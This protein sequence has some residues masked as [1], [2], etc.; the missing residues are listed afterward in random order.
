MICRAVKHA[1]RTFGAFTE[2]TLECNDAARKAID[3]LCDD[4]GFTQAWY[5]ERTADGFSKMKKIPVLIL[6]K[7][8]LGLPASREDAV[9]SLKGAY[10]ISMDPDLRTCMNVIVGRRPN[11]SGG[12]VLDKF[13]LYYPDNKAATAKFGTEWP[14]IHGYS[15]RTAALSGT[16]NRAGLD[17]LRQ[18]T[19]QAVN[20]GL[21][22]RA[23]DH[24]LVID[25][26]SAYEDCA[27]VS[28][29]PDETDEMRKQRIEKMVKAMAAAYGGDRGVLAMSF[30]PVEQAQ[31][32]TALQSEWTLLQK[33]MGSQ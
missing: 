11:G 12:Y 18:G 24:G 30:D 3:S 32:V 8:M 13:S 17:D 15:F 2:K 25:E 29:P 7:A 31:G 26:D 1:E 21:P 28:T 5:T 33:Q 4:Y 20:S 23:E 6:V 22:F 10:P 14:L 16:L 9:Q 19:I 27:Y